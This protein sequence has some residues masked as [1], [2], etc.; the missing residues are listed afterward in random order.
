MIDVIGNDK[1]LAY[2]SFIRYNY[3]IYC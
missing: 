2:F 1:F 3:N